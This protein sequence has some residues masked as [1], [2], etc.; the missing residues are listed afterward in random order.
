MIS[1]FSVL[2]DRGDIL[3]FGPLRTRLV[4]KASLLMA[5]G[6]V[7]VGPAELRRIIPAEL[8]GVLEGEPIF[9][10]EGQN[11]RLI[12]LFPWPTTA[13]LIL[14]LGRAELG[15]FPDAIVGICACISPFVEQGMLDLIERLGF[16]PGGCTWK[17]I[18]ELYDNDDM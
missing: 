9:G 5:D 15:G 2:G 6:G 16:P 10:G 17:Q 11:A 4:I 12:S 13:A 8:G 18:I 1:N 3:S 7:G 14:A